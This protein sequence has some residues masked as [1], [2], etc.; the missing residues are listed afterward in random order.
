[1]SKVQGITEIL[2]IFP[3]LATGQRKRRLSSEE[4]KLVER[5]RELSESDRIAMRYLVDA[6]RSVSRF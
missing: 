5:Y 6:M 3:W 2:G 1:M 4:L